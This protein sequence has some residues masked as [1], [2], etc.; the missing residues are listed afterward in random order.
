[1]LLTYFNYGF[2]FTKLCKFAQFSFIFK[3][4][5]MKK[6][7]YTIIVIVFGVINSYSQ[8]NDKKFAAGVVASP[9]IVS[10]SNPDVKYIQND[11]TR[12]GYNFGVA[13]DIFF[14]SNFAFSTGI[15]M[16]NISSKAKFNEAINKFNTADSVYSLTSNAI[17][18]YK[19]QYVLVPISIK[20]I[21]NEVGFMRYLFEFGVDP[22][23]KTKAYA[24]VSQQNISKQNIKDEVNLFNFGYHIGVGTHLSLPGNMILLGE[25]VYTNGLAN[26]SKTKTI[27]SKTNITRDS[28]DKISINNVALKVGILF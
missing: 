25:L 13:T 17:V 27:N 14:T 3:L 20:G 19:L 7:I 8:T 26:I 1:M 16:H 5:N 6:I 10:W 24:D 23:I 18:T 12:L 15:F 11:G 22:M 9:I 2:I 28:P 4:I 21:S